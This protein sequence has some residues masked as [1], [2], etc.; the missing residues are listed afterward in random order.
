MLAYVGSKSK[1]INSIDS[2]VLL[3]GYYSFSLSL[4]I[5]LSSVSSVYVCLRTLY[6]F[7]FSVLC[8]HFVPKVYV[9]FS[10]PREAI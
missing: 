10:F 9:G 8:L 4:S 6:R 5:A 7:T 1:L 2:N 3:R